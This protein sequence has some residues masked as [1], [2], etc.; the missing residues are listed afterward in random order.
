MNELLA[1]AHLLWS[2][3]PARLKA[4]AGATVDLIDQTLTVRRDTK[5]TD[6][7][8]RIISLN[9]NAVAAIVELYRRA[10]DNGGVAPT[11]YLFPPA[12][13]AQIFAAV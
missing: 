8:E 4:Y 9:A 7:G 12:K 5:K 1:S 13:M 2:E 10:E 6:A 11:H 3:S